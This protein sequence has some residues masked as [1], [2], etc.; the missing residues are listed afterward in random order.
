[1]PNLPG[2][3]GNKNY[4]NGRKKEYRIVKEAKERG[5]DISQRSRG[6]H[7]PVDVFSIFIKEKRIELTQS[8]PNSMSDK[9]K[10][11]LENKWVLLNATYKVRFKV[12]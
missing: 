3:K 8:K 9:A 5:A 7:S 6:S 2:W 1:M 10:R 11:T 4:N 12:Q